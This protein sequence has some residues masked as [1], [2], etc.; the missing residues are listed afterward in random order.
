MKQAI[1]GVTPASEK[2]VTVMTVWPSVA[3]QGFGP[4]TSLGRN[5]GQLYSNDTGI[6]PFT[7]GNIA[8]LLTIPIAL[9][10][11]FQRIGPFIATRYRVT[12]KRVIV[13]RGM[14]SKE[15]RSVELDQFDTVEI[16]RPP[17]YEWFDAGDL[18]FLKENRETFQLRGVS[19]PEAFRRV[20]VKSQQAYTEVKKALELEAAY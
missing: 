17:G 10:L 7:L 9:V 20:C 2:E 3:G 5:L 14:K 4:F 6:Y 13:E 11:Y 16:R 12:N 1:A 19:R 15:E 8:C 18:V